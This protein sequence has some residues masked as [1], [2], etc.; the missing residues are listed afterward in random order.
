MLYSPLLHNTYLDDALFIGAVV[1]TLLLFI[2]MAL[3]DR[4]KDKDED[5]ETKS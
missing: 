3:N 4:K 2:G 1:L 5:D